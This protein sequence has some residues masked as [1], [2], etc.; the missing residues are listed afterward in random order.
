MASAP[1][2]TRAIY[3]MRRPV[4]PLSAEY[5]ND[6]PSPTKSGHHRDVRTPGRCARTTRGVPP[7][8]GTVTSD[9]PSSTEYNSM[10]SAD[11][12]PPDGRRAGATSWGS[13]PATCTFHTETPL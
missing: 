13:P 2:S 10:P 12:E 3:N 1:S 5:T 6:L 7:L 11:H 4:R 9:V 8:D